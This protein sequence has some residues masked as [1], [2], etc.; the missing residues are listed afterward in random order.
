MHDKIDFLS[1]EEERLRISHTICSIIRKIDF[2]KDLDKTLNVYTTARGMF[3]NLDLVTEQ[4]IF[5]TNNLAA[6]AHQLTK[7]RHTQKTKNF[8]KACIAYSHIT[9]PTL[10]SAKR[11]N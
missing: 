10:E 1:N 4:L 5:S 11:Q 7:G 6:K 2:G 3:I 9:I 8:C